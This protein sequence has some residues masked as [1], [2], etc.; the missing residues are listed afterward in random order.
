M[1]VMMEQVVG[2]YRMIRWIAQMMRRVKLKQ[3]LL[4]RGKDWCVFGD[5]LI[6]GCVWSLSCCEAIQLFD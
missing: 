6:F 1:G 3:R 2:V 4:V 5:G